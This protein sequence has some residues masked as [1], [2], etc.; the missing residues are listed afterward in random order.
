[1]GAVRR[2]RYALDPV[3]LAS[4]ALYAANRWLWKPHTESTF[5]DGHFNDLLLIPCALPLVLWL[6]RRLGWRAHDGPPQ[7]GEFALHLLVWSIV[8]EGLA[9]ALCGVVGDPRDVIAYATGGV[10]AWCWW[11]RPADHLRLAERGCRG[12]G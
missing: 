4:C 8:A 6:H 11:L 9:P 3:C 5:F 12:R 2:F 10:A 7:L 1:M